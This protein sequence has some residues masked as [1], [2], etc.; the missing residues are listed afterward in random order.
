MNAIL[1]PLSDGGMLIML[2]GL[3]ESSLSFGLPVYNLR[4]HHPW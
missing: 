2:S 4:E 3:V 1:W